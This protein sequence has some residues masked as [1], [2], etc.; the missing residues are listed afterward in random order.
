M[1]HVYISLCST[2]KTINGF[3]L[4]IEAIAPS[5]MQN[6]YNLGLLSFFFLKE[7]RSFEFIVLFIL[8]YSLFFFIALAQSNELS[9]LSIHFHIGRLNTL[10]FIEQ[11][12]NILFLFFIF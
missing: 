1:D 10:M 9:G 11:N 7:K 5:S 4:N 2:A 8:L 12:R 3:T 6:L